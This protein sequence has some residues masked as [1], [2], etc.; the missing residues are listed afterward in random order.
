M[1]FAMRFAVTPYCIRVYV[2]PGRGPFRRKSLCHKGLR[3]FGGAIIVPNKL[4][5]KKTPPIMGVRPVR[6]LS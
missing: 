2:A 1:A 5:Y 4:V 6:L 3:R